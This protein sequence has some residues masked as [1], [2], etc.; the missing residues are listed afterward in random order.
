MIKKMTGKQAIDYA[1]ARSARAQK[2]YE[3]VQAAMA[4]GEYTG[5]YI[6]AIGRETFYYGFDGVDLHCGK[7]PQNRSALILERGEADVIEEARA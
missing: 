1:R 2:H 7:H 5:C 3:S 6:Y 4:K